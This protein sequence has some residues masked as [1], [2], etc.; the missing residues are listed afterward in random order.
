MFHS[1]WLFSV[2]FSVNEI[3]SNI[4][5]SRTAVYFE[6]F[7]VVIVGYKS[8]FLKKMSLNFARTFSKFSAS[9]KLTESRTTR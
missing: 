7:S 8:N 5:N 3:W 4:R 1:L 2:V 6:K 9:Q